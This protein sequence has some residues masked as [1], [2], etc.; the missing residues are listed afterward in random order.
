[1]FSLFA[2][3]LFPL[4]S[5]KHVEFPQFLQASRVCFIARC[6]RSS[7]YSKGESDW[8]QELGVFLGKSGLFGHL[9][10]AV[11]AF[12]FVFLSLPPSENPT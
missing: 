1:M 3:V 5:G 6:G 12:S 2:L 7:L 10:L 11:V 4:I 9:T 8:R